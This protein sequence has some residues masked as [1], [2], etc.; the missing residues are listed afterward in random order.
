MCVMKGVGFSRF[1]FLNGGMIS[2]HIKKE[3][4][5][6]KIAATMKELRYKSLFFLCIVIMRIG[7]RIPNSNI[8]LI[9]RNPHERS[10]LHKIPRMCRKKKI[11]TAMTNL[12]WRRLKNLVFFSSRNKKATRI[13][14]AKR[15]PKKTVNGNIKPNDISKYWKYL[16]FF[17]E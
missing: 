15:L 16:S 8:F 5:I 11:A 12:F 4:N 6:I 10:L 13:I 2:N 7:N 9:I 3:K 17:E 1:A 14:N